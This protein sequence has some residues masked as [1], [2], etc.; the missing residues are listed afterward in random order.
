MP[1]ARV[2]L[3]LAAYSAS[4]VGNPSSSS[5]A[6]VSGHDFAATWHPEFNA[7][8]GGYE[9][10]GYQHDEGVPLGAGI[11]VFSYRDTLINIQASAP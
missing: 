3:A 8:A 9:M 4:I 6:T 11:W 5:S 10:S 1:S 7:G 2:G